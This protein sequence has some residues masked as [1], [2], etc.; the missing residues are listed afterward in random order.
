MKKLLLLF[1]TISMV[2]NVLAMQKRKEPAS[3]VTE[4]QEAKAIKP[5]FDF[6]EMAKLEKLPRDAQKL[7]LLQVINDSL[8]IREA[9]REIR[10]IAT[11]SKTFYALIN[12]DDVNSQLIRALAQRFT[13]GNAIEAAEILGTRAALAW[14]S[15]T[16]PEAIRSNVLRILDSMPGEEEEI[17]EDTEEDTIDKTIRNIIS[18][19]NT[20]AAIKQVAHN[21]YAMIWLLRTIL[22]KLDPT[23]ALINNRHMSATELV[24]KIYPEGIQNELVRKWIA[25]Q[26]RQSAAHFNILIAYQ[27]FDKNGIE[28]LKKLQS[29]GIDILDPAYFP[30]GWWNYIIYAGLPLL[31]YLINAGINLSQQDISGDTILHRLMEDIMV[32]RPPTGFTFM[33]KEQQQSRL[34]LLKRSLQ[35]HANPNIRNNED[36]TPL[37]LAKDKYEKTRN[38]SPEMQHYFIQAIEIL[39]AAQK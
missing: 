14:S 2:S 18:Y 38:I 36:K 11:L 22:K 23:F 25:Y 34:N 31:E 27:T 26:D 9:A 6:Q 30:A 39:K 3:P 10:K 19:L 15:I 29:E 32:W 37:E 28:P 12:S 17:E 8:N 24:Q 7:I 5:Y 21:Q 16:L 4:A 20:N 1:L 35:A 33:A 13:H